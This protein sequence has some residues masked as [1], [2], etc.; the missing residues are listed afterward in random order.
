[1]EG[2]AWDFEMLCFVFVLAI[3]FDTWPYDQGTILL[4]KGAPLKN[5]G[6]WWGYHLGPNGKLEFG[7]GTL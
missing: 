1:M 3:T 5:I 6:V 4:I 2:H 7:G